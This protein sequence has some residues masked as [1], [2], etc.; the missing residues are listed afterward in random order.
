MKKISILPLSIYEFNASDELTNNVLNYVTNLPFIKNV[1]NK[2]SATDEQEFV[3]EEFKLWCENCLEE[4]KTEEYGNVNWKF[5]ITQMWANKSNYAEFHHKHYHPNSIL[6][7]VFYLNSIPKG[8][9]TK[10]YLENPYYYIE[11]A[12]ILSLASKKNKHEISDT[13]QSTKGKLVIFPSTL[14]HTVNPFN[15]IEPRYSV[16]FNTFFKGSLG[17]KGSSTFI[18]F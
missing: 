17:S 9:E 6:S 18:E 4:V 15:N 7:A 3:F 11:T 14:W 2:T 8:G 5:Y 16:S 13:I 1:N 12:K 10:F